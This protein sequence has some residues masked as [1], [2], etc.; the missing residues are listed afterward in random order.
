MIEKDNFL[1][2]LLLA[3]RNLVYIR[4]IIEF[5]FNTYTVCRETTFFDRI[6][7]EKLKCRPVFLIKAINLHIDNRMRRVLQDNV[8]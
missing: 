6:L 5:R 7:I 3:Y 2:G 4:K 1:C 8:G